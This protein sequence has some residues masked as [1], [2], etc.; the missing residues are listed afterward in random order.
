[1]VAQV[2]E[3]WG[4]QVEIRGV[5]VG[6]WVAEVGRAEGLVAVVEPVE[7]EGEEGGAGEFGEEAR[8]GGVGGGDE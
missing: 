8:D 2:R 1:M 5:R 6:I 7:G 4:G 3:G